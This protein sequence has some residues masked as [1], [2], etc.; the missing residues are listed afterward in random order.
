MPPT[1]ARSDQTSIDGYDRLAYRAL[2]TELK[3]RSQV[4]L[5]DIEAYERS[6]QDR[7]PVLDKLRYL[8]STEPL[9]GYDE[10]GPDA[11]LAALAEADL[12]SL[13]A[14]RGYES[15]L[16]RRE[17]VLTGV[18]QLR[19]GRVRAGSADPDAAEPPPYQG[20]PRGLKDSAATV[21]VFGL[22]AIAA[23]LAFVSVGV[24]VFVVISA[25][26]PNA[27]G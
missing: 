26:A 8:R 23:V 9:P 10:L 20:A 21:G 7:G 16:R 11:I 14:V 22:V 17:E 1:A 27:L 15:R 24:A 19:R 12:G 18:E 6:H 5:S 3:L 13:H 25:V 4:E 2:V